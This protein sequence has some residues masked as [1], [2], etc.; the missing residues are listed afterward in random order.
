M[1]GTAWAMRAPTPVG[2]PLR[3]GVAGGRDPHAE[4]PGG[5]DAHGGGRRAGLDLV[6][7]RD[8]LVDRYRKGLGRLG[9]PALELEPGGA[10]ARGID[11][12]HLAGVAD[13]RAAGVT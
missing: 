3:G 6:G 2:S 7:D 8:R 4:D 1:P 12:D 9:L 5:A 11:A 13:Q 10:G